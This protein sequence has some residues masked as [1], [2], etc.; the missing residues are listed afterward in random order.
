MVLK[1]DPERSETV[2][3]CRIVALGL[4]VI[5]WKRKGRVL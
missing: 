1:I 3:F 5:W 4:I 2:D